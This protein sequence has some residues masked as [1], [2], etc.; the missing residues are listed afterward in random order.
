MMFR[1]RHS[2]TNHSESK[3]A[4]DDAVKSLHTI[5]ERSQ[6]ALTMSHEIRDFQQTD[7][8]F[9]HIRQVIRQHY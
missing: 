9:D 5:R 8:F 6:E 1:P 2:E 4:R 7:A 3:Q